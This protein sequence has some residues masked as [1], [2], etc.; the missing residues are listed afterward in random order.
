M[1]EGVPFGFDGSE[2][3]QLNWGE[4]DWSRDLG[5]KLMERL[6]AGIGKRQRGVSFEDWKRRKEAENRLKRRLLA[7]IEA[8]EKA[9]NAAKARLSAQQREKNK[10][11]VAR[12]RARKAAEAQAK[13]YQAK[14]TLKRSKA[15]E[16]VKRAESQLSYLKWLR[17]DLVKGKSRNAVAS[18]KSMGSRRAESADLSKGR[19]GKGGLKHYKKAE[20]S[21]DFLS[22]SK[23]SESQLFTASISRKSDPSGSQRSQ[24]LLKSSELGAS[25]LDGKDDWSDISVEVCNLVESQG[26]SAISDVHL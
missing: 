20:N 6:E 8:E 10:A 21:E 19:K 26:F 23:L 3:L 1:S 14:T 12:W 15:S 5:K 16:V 11:K 7:D 25:C 4:Q 13:R 18:G 2:L 17:E 24:N 9:E 22:D